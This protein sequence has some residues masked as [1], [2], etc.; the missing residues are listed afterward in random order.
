MKRKREEWEYIDIL[1]KP[2]TYTY[3]ESAKN[4]SSLANPHTFLQKRWQIK[5]KPM[6]RTVHWNC[7]E[8]RCSQLHFLVR[9]VRLSGNRHRRVRLRRPVAL[10]RIVLRRVALRRLALIGR[11]LR[12]VRLRRHRMLLSRRHWSVIRLLRRRLLLLLRRWRALWRRYILGAGRVRWLR[13][14]RVLIRRLKY[15][16]IVGRRVVRRIR[17]RGGGWRRRGCCLCVRRGGCRRVGI[18]GSAGRRAHRRRIVALLGATVVR[19]RIAARIAAATTYRR[20][21]TLRHILSAWTAVRRLPVTTGRTTAVVW[22]LRRGRIAGWSVLV[23]TTHLRLTGRRRSVIRS[24]R[25]NGGWW[26]VAVGRRLVVWS[27]RAL[28][29]GRRIGAGG[30]CVRTALTTGRRLLRLRVVVR[31]RRNMS[32]SRPWVLIIAERLVRTLLRIST[33]I[34]PVLLWACVC[35]WSYK[36]VEFKSV[37]PIRCN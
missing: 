9:N 4:L 28:S 35:W 2:E 31:L 21:A 11:R 8:G 33:G 32:G 5:W 36:T 26:T 7:R 24:R 30:R 25:W 18:A 17:L 37:Y 1:K 6:L 19:G 34:R 15:G 3:N 29:R 13:R 27:W 23:A 22:L 10:L 12:R 16:W 20:A 14:R